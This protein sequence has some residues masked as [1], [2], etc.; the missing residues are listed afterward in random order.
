MNIMLMAIDRLWNGWKRKFH[1]KKFLWKTS[2]ILTLKEDLG[3]VKQRT[4]ESI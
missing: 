2:L 4:A 3:N 1:V